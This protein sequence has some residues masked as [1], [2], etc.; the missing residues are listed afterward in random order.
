MDLRPAPGNGQQRQARVGVHRHT[1]GDRTQ[2]VLVIEAVAVGIAGI[3]IDVVILGPLGHRLELA[4]APHVMTRH[5]AGVTILAIGLVPGGHHSIQAQRLS[6]RGDQVIRGG[7]GH[8]QRTTRLAVL[9]EELMCPRLKD[10][11]QVGR[12]PLSRLLHLC[13]RPALGGP[14]PL[15]GDEHG[16]QRLADGVEDPKD[17]VFDAGSTGT[18]PHP[19]ERLA[20]DPA[21]GTAQ[22]R[23]VEVEERR[24]A[25]CRLMSGGCGAGRIR[26]RCHW[27]QAT[28]PAT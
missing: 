14:H 5:P 11:C 19:S 4:S 24:T 10:V 2:Q 26:G 16:R 23:P 20:V 28:R 25:V 27:M 3:E 6:Q 17:Q 1:V 9:V 12:S 22:Q 8:H 13:L 21:R 18:Q 7:R 15:A